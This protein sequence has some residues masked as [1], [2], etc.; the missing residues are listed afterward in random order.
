VKIAGIEKNSFVDY[1]GHLAAV[2]FT[3]GCNWR[4][5]Y[6]HNPALLGTQPPRAWLDA[7]GA[8]A[9]LDERRGWLDAVV[10]TG[11]EPTLQTDL[12]DFLRAV[13]AKGF[14]IKLD[15]NGTRPQVLCALL[16]EGLLDYVAMDVKAPMDQYEALC[17][18]PV[19]HRAINESIDRLMASGIDYEFRTTV[20][21]Q[22]SEDDIRAVAARVRGARCY[23]LQQY[24]RPEGVEGDPRLDAP[25]QEAGLAWRLLPDLEHIVARCETRGFERPA[26][27]GAPSAA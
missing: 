4:C 16:E 8:L 13:R 1:P 9:W 7:D 10:V 6:C 20:T 15:T 3:Y 22:L 5:F 14:L 12:A 25:P 23:V 17:G 21:P 2:F 11:G 18:A 26:Q 19:D 27:A 24:R